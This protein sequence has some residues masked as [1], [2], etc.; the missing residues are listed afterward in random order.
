MSASSA[1]L[2]DGA[3]VED[4][5]TMDWVRAYFWSDSTRRVQTVLGLLWLLDGGLQ[6][7]G[8]MY[9][10]GFPAMLVG[11]A[12]GQPGWLHD[13]MVWAAKFANGDLAV[14]NTL[15]ALTQVLIGAGLL[16]RPTVK[17]AIAGSLGW[18]LV[19][20]WFGEGFGMLFMDM[21]QPLTGAPGGVFMYGL[22]GLLAWPNGRPGGIFGPGGAKLVWAGLWL[23][24]AWLWLMAPSS[25]ANA[26]HDALT[27]VDSGIG[28]I[29][30]LQSDLAS[31]ARG[32]GLVIA[33][34]LSALSAAI[35]IAVATDWHPR[36]F[37]AIS[38]VLSAVYW[39]IPQAFGGIFAGGAT[40]PNTAPLFIL[41]ACAMYPV[42]SARPAPAASAQAALA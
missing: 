31:A 14:W 24:M 11:L 41:L 35:G 40:D 39:V 29:N 25:S 10:H 17:F 5:S 13:S 42:V 15:F 6:F 28:F 37:L 20:W 4:R 21:A 22:I 30:S 33:L 34:V 36:T 8:F 26:T 18:V 32:D 1:T 23:L 16:Y 38:I 9:S 3:H 12:Q 2:A 27:G 19:V 7:Q